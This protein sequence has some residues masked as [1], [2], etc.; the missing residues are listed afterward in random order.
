[1]SEN[2]YV[3]Q[4]YR[5]ITIFSDFKISLYVIGYCKRGYFC[6]GK[7]SQKNVD[8]Q[9]LLHGGN[10]HDT[11]H[12]FLHRVIWVLFWRGG[13][14]RKEVDIAKNAKITPMRKFPHLQYHK[15]TLLYHIILFLC[16]RI[17]WSGAYCFCPVCLSVCLFVCLFVR[18]NFNI[19]FAITFEP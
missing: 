15:V 3:F 9:D 16:P 18:V 12:F 8:S 19:N 13:N 2:I 11:A 10:F 4:V 14:F 7:I 1:M 17:K 5:D 6:S